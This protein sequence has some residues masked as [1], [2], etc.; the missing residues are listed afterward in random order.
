[1]RHLHQW[2]LDVLS[3]PNNVIKKVR[4][5]CAR[6]GKNE[7]QKEHFLAHN[8]RKRCE[9]NSRSLSEELRYRDAQLK[10]DWTEEKCIEMD[11]LAQK[12]FT[13]PPSLEEFERQ[14]NLVFLCEHFWQKCTD[15]TPIRLQRSSN[16][17]HRLHRE[18]GEERLAPIPFYQYQKW[19]PS[20]SSSSG[21][22]TGGAHKFIK[23][24]SL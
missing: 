2:Q 6:Y 22:T 23:V 16:K 5:H 7:A 10:A 19:N 20:S 13:Y 14:E 8:A 11:E 4:P 3:I 15:E 17:M 21:M 24:N 9:R 18:P 12:D 1:M